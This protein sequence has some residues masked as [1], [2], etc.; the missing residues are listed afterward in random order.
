MTKRDIDTTNATL[1][2]IDEDKRTAV[3][4]GMG[5]AAHVKS[6]DIS[7]CTGG[8]GHSPDKGG[9]G[10]ITGRDVSCVVSVECEGLGLK[11]CTMETTE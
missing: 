3:T 11:I 2:V 7:H 1:V 6:N 8:R 10:H 9:S 5:T 4:R